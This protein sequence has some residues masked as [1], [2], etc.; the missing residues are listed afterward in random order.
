MKTGVSVLDFNQDIG[1]YFWNK[2]ILCLHMRIL[3]HDEKKICQLDQQIHF[4]RVKLHILQA[5]YK[6]SYSL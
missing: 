6:Y 5:K 3:M 2:T 4:T 1:T